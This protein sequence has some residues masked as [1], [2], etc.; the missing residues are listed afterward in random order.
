[1]NFHL[2]ERV[3]VIRAD[4]GGN[5][6]GSMQQSRSAILKEFRGGIKPVDV[7]VYK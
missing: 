4:D 3:E 5:P 1:M 2:A 6:M 7:K